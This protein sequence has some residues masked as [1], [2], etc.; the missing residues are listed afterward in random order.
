LQKAGKYVTVKT[1]FSV[2]TRYRIIAVED[3]DM[4]AN[5]G[6][7]HVL[8][9]GRERDQVKLEEKNEN[10]LIKFEMGVDFKV[11]LIVPEK[12]LLPHF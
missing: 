8:S 7:H 1:A 3:C 2:D 9:R 11:I 5:R 6:R 4:Q 10:D 12:E